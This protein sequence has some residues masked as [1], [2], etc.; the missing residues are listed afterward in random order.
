MFQKTLTLVYYIQSFP[1][2]YSIWPYSLV[3]LVTKNMKIFVLQKNFLR[4]L[5]SPG[6]YEHTS[7]IFKSSKGL[8]LQNII[9]FSILELI[10]LYFNNQLPVQFKNILIQNKPVNPCNMRDDNLLFIPHTNTTH[11]GT[12]IIKLFIIKKI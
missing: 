12:T 11:F 3:L 6:Y 5:I 7:S 10:Y 1:N 4:L 9:Q 8:K 2:I